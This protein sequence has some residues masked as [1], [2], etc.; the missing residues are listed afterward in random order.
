MSAEAPQSGSGL[1]AEYDVNLS[2]ITNAST[3]SFDPSEISLELGLESFTANTSFDDS[4]FTSY[5]AT[6]PSD[7]DFT[8]TDWETSF[9]GNEDLDF[10]FGSIEPV[11]SFALSDPIEF[12]A[13]DFTTLDFDPTNDFL[14]LELV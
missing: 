1:F 4:F 7:F 2:D 8:S 6:L 12:A 5:E 13:V 9:L 3:L 11:E 10:S 14:T